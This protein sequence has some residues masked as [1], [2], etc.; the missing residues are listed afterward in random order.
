MAHRY[1]G[2]ICFSTGEYTDKQGEIKK[3]WSKAGAVF[4]NEATGDLSIKFEAMPAPTGEWSGFMRI[5]LK[6]R[7]AAPTTEQP[8]PAGRNSEAWQQAK[9]RFNKKSHSDDDSININDIPF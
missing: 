7:G 2:D 8:Q 5:F 1:I 6:E 4:E 3:R 9:E